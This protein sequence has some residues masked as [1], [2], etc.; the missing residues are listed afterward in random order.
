MEPLEH[1]QSWLFVAIKVAESRYAGLF[2]GKKPVERQLPIPA[3]LLL[4]IR[5]SR[6]LSIA[7]SV[8]T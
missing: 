3:A 7:D 8:I 1:E 4:G 5:F 2:V 6:L